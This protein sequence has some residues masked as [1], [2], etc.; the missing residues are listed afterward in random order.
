MKPATPNLD[1]W[2]IEKEVNKRLAE[3]IA[4]TPRQ[5]F[6]QIKGENPERHWNQTEVC[7]YV[8]QIMILVVGETWYAEYRDYPEG[9]ELTYIRVSSS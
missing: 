2:I 4:F 3:A 8:H 7:L 6:T 5:I 1:A 9:N